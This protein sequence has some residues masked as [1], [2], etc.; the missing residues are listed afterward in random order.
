MNFNYLQQQPPP[1][2]LNPNLFPNFDQNYYSQNNFI[3]NQNQNYSSAQPNFANI[4]YEPNPPIIYS[5]RTS[6]PSDMDVVSPSQLSSSKIITNNDNFQFQ[7]TRDGN[8]QSPILI[9]DELDQFERNNF[10][11]PNI[12]K[13]KRQ[14][15]IPTN[16]D[17]KSVV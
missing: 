2:Q 1:P 6:S 5:N 8:Q 17:R 9:P 11:D 4:Y 15:P 3:N 13:I 14:A 7:F 10:Y 12:H 16:P